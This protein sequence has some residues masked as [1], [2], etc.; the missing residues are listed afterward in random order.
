MILQWKVQ[1]EEFFAETGR[2]VLFFSSAC[3][4]L[5]RP[6]LRLRL[7]LDQLYFIGNRSVFIVCLTAFFTGLVFALQFY[8]GFRVISADAF[9][10]PASALS[11]ARELSPV[12]TAVVVTGRAGAAMAAELGT[13]RI[14]EQIDAMEVMAVNPIQYL[15]SPRIFAGF[16]A[17]PMV[18]ILFLLIGNIGSYVACVYILNI[19][20]ALYFSHLKSFVLAKDIFQGLI[21]AAAFGVMFSTVSTYCGYVTSGGSGAVGN[22]TNRAVVITLVLILM[23]DYFLTLIIR[24]FL[25]RSVG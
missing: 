5:V 2:I 18:S 12:F 10:G 17:L 4:W 15:V 7:F 22:A 20:S 21:K 19:D 6:P 16:F 11:L 13:M 14:T 8:F 3:I 23:S 9:V 25:Y 1:L 24:F